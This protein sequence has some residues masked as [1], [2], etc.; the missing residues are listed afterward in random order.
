MMLTRLLRVGLPAVLAGMLGVPPAHADIYMW[1]DASGVA[2]VSNLAPPEN[3]HVT[4]VIHASAPKATTS[5]DDA[6]E[7]SRHAEV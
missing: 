1:I 6:R 5:G 2:N 4:S 7:A 3:A